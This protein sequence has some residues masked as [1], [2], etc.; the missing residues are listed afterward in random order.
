MMTQTVERRG[1]VRHELGTGDVVAGVCTCHGY[2]VR[3]GVVQN[4]EHGCV[5]TIERTY[6]RDE[7]HVLSAEHYVLI[8][9]LAD[10]IDRLHESAPYHA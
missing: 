3:W 4:V 7:R 5:F 9:T 10:T 1:D 8:E 2:R 6:V